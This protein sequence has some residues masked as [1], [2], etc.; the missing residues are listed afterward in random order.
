MNPFSRQLVG[1]ATKKTSAWLGVA[2]LVVCAR[3]PL[4][5]CQSPSPSQGEGS[6]TLVQQQGPA[7]LCLSGVEGMDALH[8]R[9]ADVLKVTVE[10]EGGAALEVRT[11]D[12]L[13]QSMGWKVLSA[14]PAETSPPKP[15]VRTRWRKTYELEALSPES[16]MLQVEPFSWREKGGVFS[17]VTFKP[18]PIQVRTTIGEPDLKKLRDPT[19]IERV[20]SAGSWPWLP[21]AGLGLGTAAVM[22]LAAYFLRRRSQAARAALTPEALAL[23]ELDRLER[24]RWPQKGRGERFVSLLSNVLRNYLEKKW[25]LPARRQTTPEFLRTLSAQTVLDEVQSKFLAEFLDQFDLAKF[26]GVEPAA[27]FCDDL[28]KEVREFVRGQASPVKG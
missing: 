2:L 27:S 9:F 6:K 10:I 25:N 17:T 19:V 16:L 12:T 21:W 5:W 8:M 24:L 15:G 14:T 28:A 1:D 4:A 3:C 22:G 13:T 20:P 18:I 23:H 11:P 7:K 26:A